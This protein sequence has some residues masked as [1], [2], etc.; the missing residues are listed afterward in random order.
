MSFVTLFCYDL[1]SEQTVPDKFL[2]LQQHLLTPKQHFS[3]AFPGTVLLAR[4]I[5]V[6]VTTH[7]SFST[8]EPA[9]NQLSESRCSHYTLTSFSNLAKASLFKPKAYYSTMSDQQW[10]AHFYLRVFPTIHKMWVTSYLL[11]QSVV[12]L[13]NLNLI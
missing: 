3:Q 11:T 9:I 6:G 7:P 1:G 2:E 10:D 12:V 8:Y 5:W 13:S 4:I